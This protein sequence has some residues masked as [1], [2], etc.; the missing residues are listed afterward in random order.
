VLRLLAPTVT[1]AAVAFAASAAP[2]AP[3]PG[4]VE[5]ALVGA[6]NAFRAENGLPR[7]T[8]EDR[9][10]DE[11]RGFAQYLARTN[12]FSHTAD[13]REPQERAEAAGY[14]YCDLAENIAYE[15]DSS[16]VTL[17]RLVQRL[18]SGWEASPG[19]RRNLLNRRVTETGV[20]VALAPRGDQKYVAVQV[21]GRPISARYSF[22]IENRSDGP[23][24]YDFDGEHTRLGPHAIMVHTTCTQ[25]DLDFDRPL[26]SGQRRFAV[27][28]GATYVLSSTLKGVQIEV[29]QRPRSSG[30]LDED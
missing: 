10:S 14:S 11:A 7:L 18:M 19:H 28:P 2:P 6:A 30:R 16:G 24:G 9:L 13:G 20:G 23:V 25:G 1:A 8:R 17:D 22:R 4:Q 5:T 27:A 12:T 3:E 15:V 21:F 26:A 29:Q